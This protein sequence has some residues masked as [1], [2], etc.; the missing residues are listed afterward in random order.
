[1]PIIEFDPLETFVCISDC[2]REDTFSEK[3]HGDRLG[4]GVCSSHTQYSVF[5]ESFSS[6]L[7]TLL[8]RSEADIILLRR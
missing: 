1:M 2:E 8:N 5:V 6:F 3:G 4:E 7:K